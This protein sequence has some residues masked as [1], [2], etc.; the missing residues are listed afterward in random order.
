[1]L[2]VCLLLPPLLLG[3]MLSMSYVESHLLGENRRAEAP[4]PMPVA[5]LQPALLSLSHR[6]RHRALSS[7]PRREVIAT[8][9]TATLARA[10]ARH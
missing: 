4:D 7:R 8:R 9:S 6:P 1:M 10:H 5:P 3:F 2:W